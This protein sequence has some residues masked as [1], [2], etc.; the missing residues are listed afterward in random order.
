[1]TFVPPIRAYE[2][3]GGASGRQTRY[4]APRHEAR[5]LFSGPFP[6][7]ML[8]DE[9]HILCDLSLSG[10]A[11]IGSARGGQGEALSEGA[12]VAL[13]LKLGTALLFEGRARVARREETDLGTKMGLSL[14]GRMLDLEE[15]S[16]RYRHEILCLK[17]RAS[18][19]PAGAQP[20]AGFRALCADLVDRLRACRE[21][22][23]V[24]DVH[25][26][27]KSEGRDGGS[28]L[29]ATCRNAI[30]PSWQQAGVKANAAL[31]AVL[32]DPQALSTMKGF[33]ERV[34]TAEL[35][36]GPL[37]QRAYRKP[38]GHPGDYA[39]AAALHG[40]PEPVASLYATFLDALARDAFAW[41]PGRTIGLA[42]AM[43]RE[44]GQQKDVAPFNLASIGCGGAEELR[45]LLGRGRM[46]RQLAVTLVEQD[47]DALNHAY[48]GLAGLSIADPARVS[49]RAL[50][51]SHA[52]LEDE[53]ELAGTLAGQNLIVAPTLLDYLRHRP[54]TQLL[55][56]LYRAL[57]P[58]G[59]IL[60]GCLR[61]HS[62]SSRWVSELL[63][64]WSM[65]HRE[66]DEVFALGAGLPR[67]KIDVRLIAEGDVHLLAIRRPRV[68]R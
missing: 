41:M 13:A 53:G 67:A 2:H 55:R 10:L 63:C 22:L 46:L 37:W 1:L 28:S 27:D 12:E 29:I 44:L 58:G 15:V 61:T 16:A 31:D 26:R 23:E 6:V 34:L 8:A 57:A 62:H 36:V 56:A 14:L 21:V 11:V 20:P 39:F 7:A 5:A 59:L 17:L 32:E 25:A 9:P 50:H 4:R 68:D 3:L 30:R 33:T 38:L 54:A 19:E 24:E 60:A 52:Q 35:A 18:F 43:T 42:Q 45:A 47:A 48:E 40:P 66:R 65:I 51:A 64:D 49:L